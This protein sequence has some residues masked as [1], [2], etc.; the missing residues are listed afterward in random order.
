M[1]YFGRLEEFD[2]SA[3][4]VDSYLRGYMHAFYRANNVHDSAK[5]D[6]FLSVVGSNAY[7][8]LKS[9]LASTP[10]PNKTI[11]ELY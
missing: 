9:L 6:V 7:K 1:S 5:L 2:C 4:D 10:P 8:L 3:T 11:N